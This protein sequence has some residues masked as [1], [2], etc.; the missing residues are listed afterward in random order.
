MPGTMYDPNAPVS[1]AR[2]AVGY[3]GLGGLASAADYG[4][5]AEY[6]AAH[7]TLA[8]VLPVF[9]TVSGLASA[10]H[11]YKR[12]RNSVGWAVMWFLGGATAPILMPAIAIFQGYAK[13]AR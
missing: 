8:V 11:G 13:P 4:T 7:P 12:N 6:R 10:Y 2:K 5:W 1:L 9:C 3:A